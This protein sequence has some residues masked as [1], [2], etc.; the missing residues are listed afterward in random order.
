MSQAIKIDNLSF[1]YPDGQAALS[2]VSLT[3]N[4][5]E[6][7]ALIGPNGAGKS[8][9]LLHLNGILHTNGAVKILERKVSDGNLRWVRSRVGLV[10]QNPDDQ[11]FS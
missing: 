3:V 2:G 5:G 9:L 10:F 8:T 11:L 4:A 7:V 6:S 1:S